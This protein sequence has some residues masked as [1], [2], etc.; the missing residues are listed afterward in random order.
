MIGNKCIIAVVF[1]VA[2][3]AAFIKRTGEADWLRHHVPASM[4]FSV[5]HELHP[6]QSGNNI[7]NNIKDFVSFFICCFIPYGKFNVYISHYKVLRRYF[8]CLYVLNM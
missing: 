6:V 5:C 4:F 3:A 7:S 8:Q 1:S 2:V